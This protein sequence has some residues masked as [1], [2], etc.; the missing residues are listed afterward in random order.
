LICAGDHGVAERLEQLA[1][2]AE[3]TM[4]EITVLE[5]TAGKHTVQTP[6]LF[7]VIIITIRIKRCKKLYQ[8]S[9]QYCSFENKI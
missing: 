4:E 7:V 1:R 8:F 6:N 3:K 9:I 5:E 2:E